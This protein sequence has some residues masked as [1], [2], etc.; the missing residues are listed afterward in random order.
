MEH[1]EKELKVVKNRLIKANLRLVI[2]IAKKYLNRG[3]S[4]L[5]LIQEEH[6]SHEGGRKI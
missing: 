4:F 3:L 1:I 5:D 2:N 6:G